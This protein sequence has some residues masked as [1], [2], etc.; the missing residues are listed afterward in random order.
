MSVCKVLEWW[1]VERQPKRTLEISD[2]FSSNLWFQRSTKIFGIETESL[3]FVKK[4]W[5]QKNEHP[6]KNSSNLN[7]NLLLWRNSTQIPSLLLIGEAESTGYRGGQTRTWACLLTD[8]IPGDV[9]LGEIQPCSSL[10]WHSSLPDFSVISP[11]KRGFSG[12]LSYSFVTCVKC[13]SLDLSGI[14]NHV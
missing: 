4:I 8:P 14:S 7:L 3:L 6:F 1:I 2:G 13:K 5:N 10:K 9:K 12:L 11:K